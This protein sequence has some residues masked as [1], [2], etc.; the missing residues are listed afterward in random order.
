VSVPASILQL[1]ARPHHERALTVLF[2]THNV[3]VVRAIA[4]DVMVLSQG[5]MVESGPVDEMLD[6]PKDPYTQRLI[7]DTPGFGGPDSEARTA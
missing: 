1:L 2:V 4:D 6:N 3:A 5:R 7:A